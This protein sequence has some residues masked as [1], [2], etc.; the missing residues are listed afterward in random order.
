MKAEAPLKFFHACST[1]KP[2]AVVS[3]LGSGIHPDA[4]DQ[5][6]LTGL[7]WAGRKGHIAVAELLLNRGADIKAGDNR[8]RTA[9]F[10]AVT[11]KRIEFVRFLASY[12]ANVNPIDSHG[13]SPLDFSTVSVHRRMAE[14]L[15]ELGAVS[16][17]APCTPP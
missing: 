5:Y 17:R 4:R 3:F 11:Y 15:A 14:V 13:W 16:G 12:G 1:G 9:L 2:E 6:N 7:I 10:P 8:G